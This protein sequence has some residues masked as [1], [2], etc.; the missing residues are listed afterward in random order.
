MQGG[1]KKKQTLKTATRTPFSQ[2]RNTKKNTKH[3]ILRSAHLFNNT[4]VLLCISIREVEMFLLKER[5]EVHTE[6]HS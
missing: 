6:M 1:C 5:A 3:E 2:Q 4:C